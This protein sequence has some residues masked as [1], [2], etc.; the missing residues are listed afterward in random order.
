MLFQDYHIPQIRNGSKTVTR[1]E[2]KPNVAVG[3]V[4]MAASAAMVPDHYGHNSPMFLKDEDCDCYI[5]VQALYE[6]PLGEMTAEDARREGD[7]ETV[8]EF[9]EGWERI[10]GDGSWTPEQEVWVTEFDHVGNERPTLSWEL[11]G[12]PNCGFDRDVH[13][14]SRQMEALFLGELGPDAERRLV[15]DYHWSDWQATNRDALAGLEAA[16]E[17]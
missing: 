17:R 3:G 7:Y 12:C 8:D 13:E 11:G 2:R 1:R 5:Q 6:Q 15:C 16:D 14:R 10:N 9:T 4:Y